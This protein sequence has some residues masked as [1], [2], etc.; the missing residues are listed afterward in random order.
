MTATVTTVSV[1]LAVLTVLVIAHELGHFVVARVAG[2]RVLE[3]GFGYPPR[4]LSITRGLTTYS[5]NLLPLGGFV[6]MLGENGEVVQSDSFGAQ[7][8]LARAAV[9][10][11]GSAMNLML[12]PIC[13]TIALMLGEM[14]PCD[15]CGRVQIYG[16]QPG[17]ASA[18]AGVRDGDLIMAIDGALITDAA[19]VRQAVR[20][21]E[22]R[23]VSLRL[24]RLSDVFE[25]SVTPRMN[26]QTNALALGISLGPEYVLER[27]PLAEA[28][29]VSLTRTGEMVVNMVAGLAKVVVR[30]APAELAGPVGI[31]EMTGRAARAGTPT[32]LQ[33]MAFL[34]LNLA[35]FNILPVPGLDGARLLFVGIEAVR[36]KR[37]NPQVEGALHLA[38]M[39][40]L[41]ALMLVVSFRDIQKLVA[42]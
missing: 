34:S 10:V 33:F 11:A 22:G 14:S 25:L 8:K 7:P 40:L 32:L 15:G 36:G 38:G 24:R 35:I 1:F 26:P 42:S 31:A 2:I 20:V 39:L 9:L 37:V 27:L 6:K 29:P 16:V 28:L 13:L 19:G 23:P 21:S 3:F 12:A 17:M 5:L 30:E 18:E 41:L 4:V